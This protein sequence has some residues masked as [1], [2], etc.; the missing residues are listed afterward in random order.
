[1]KVNDPADNDN[2]LFM[3][4]LWGEKSSCSSDVREPSLERDTRAHAN[5]QGWG[6][7][8]GF[9]SWEEAAIVPPSLHLHV[10]QM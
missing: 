3:L 5:W 2:I 10:L 8:W 6:S 4:R 9:F 7:F 1:M